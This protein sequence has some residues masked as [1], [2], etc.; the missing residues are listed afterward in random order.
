MED[1]VRWMRG[2]LAAI[3]VAALL[4]GCGDK[5][6]AKD[7]YVQR[8]NAICD[9]S[10]QRFD[11]LFGD[12][13]VLQSDVPAFFKKATPIVRDQVAKL[14]DLHAPAPNHGEVKRFLAL[15]DR[16][17]ADYERAQRDETFGAKIF[18]ENG[19]KN[20]EGFSKQAAAYGLTKCKSDDQS[21][22]PKLDP[23]TFS[24]E[25]RAYVSQADAVCKRSI[26]QQKP[27]EDKYLAT[28]PPTMDAWSG[29]IPQALPLERAKLADLR[30][31]NPPAADKAT[32]EGIW[33]KNQALNDKIEAAGRAAA[34]KDENA[35]RSALKPTFSGF[36][37]VEGAERQYGFQ[38]CGPT[39]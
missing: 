11:A 24:P 33:N 25:K 39:D 22:G 29:F 5:A 4:A 8:G 32:I 10:H 19:G 2:A 1:V 17:V 13:P 3:G 16:A 15:G 35:L 7:A 6:L 36:D 9:A 37:E 28:F 30:R 20:T 27:L 34:A 12:F 23:A 21:G 14:R 38:V 31:L 18:T 26:D